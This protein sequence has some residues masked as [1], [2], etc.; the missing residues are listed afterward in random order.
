MKIY[1]IGTVAAASNQGTIDGVSYNMFEPNTDC[2]SHPIYNV[3]QTKFGDQSIVTRKKAAPFLR[4][5]YNYD[6]IFTKEYRQ[7]ERA[8]D[9]V[10]E[11]LTALYV[12]DFSKGITPSAVASAGAKWTVSLD[13]T[14]FYSA[15]AGYKANRAI[16]WNGRSWKEGSITG[17]TLNASITVDIQ[18]NRFGAMPL[19][20][21]VGGMVYPTYEAYIA[22]QSLQNFKPGVYWREDITTNEPGGYV[23]SGNI[24]FTSKYKL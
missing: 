19:A 13:D 15:T 22:P 14:F 7:I 17:L 4:I 20:D 5:T 11:S 6:N 2:Q 3:L 24:D 1:P 21:A 23:Y 9:D 16:L 12:I 18:A 10:G 8:V